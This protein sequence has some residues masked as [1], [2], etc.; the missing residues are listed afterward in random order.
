MKLQFNTKQT[1]FLG[2]L[3]VVSGYGNYTW[4]VV[5]CSKTQH[6]TVYET[7][8]TIVYDLVG[9][10]SDE[11]II[12]I[13]EK[14][15]LVCRAAYAIH[16]IREL[17]EQGLPPISNVIKQKKGGNTLSNESVDAEANEPYVYPD[18]IDGF[19]DKLTDLKCTGEVIGEVDEKLQ[20]DM[21]VV[22]EE[23]DKKRLDM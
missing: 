6:Y 12:G 10:C 3:C 15:Q 13:Q 4:E 1:L 22:V 17:D 5:G 7:S 19:L 23:L 9:V 21:N 8:E 16:Y 11:W 20:S 14:T 2:D 18:T